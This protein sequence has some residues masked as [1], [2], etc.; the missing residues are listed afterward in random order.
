M[1]GNGARTIPSW[2]GGVTSFV[3]LEKLCNLFPPEIHVIT[4]SGNLSVSNN[5][6]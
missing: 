5:H 4:E 3:F 2:I 1:N 6:D